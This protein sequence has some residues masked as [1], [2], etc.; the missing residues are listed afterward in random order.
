MKQNILKLLLLKGVIVNLLA[1]CSLASMASAFC[2]VPEITNVQF[3]EI[4][5]GQNSVI[6]VTIKNVGS[7]SGAFDVWATCEGSFTSVGA[8]TISLGSDEEGTIYVPIVASCNQVVNGKC[9]IHVKDQGCGQQ[10]SKESLGVCNPSNQCYPEN[11]KRC[12]G[13]Q[14][15]QC[16][17]GLWTPISECPI[18]CYVINGEAQCNSEAGASVPM[19]LI[20]SI[21]II[22]VV[23]PIFIYKI[24]KKKKGKTINLTKHCPECG[25][26]I[27]PGDKFCKNCGKEL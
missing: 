22:I 13:N 9:T 26:K 6:G 10:A 2:G 21:L 14:V 12:V 3:G 19:W 18:G 23:V 5:S 4:G 1:F 17:N 20:V 27:L 8:N 7:D 24:S 16:R 25:V 15:E 11:A